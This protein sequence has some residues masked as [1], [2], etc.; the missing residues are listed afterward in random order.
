MNEEIKDWGLG[1]ALGKKKKEGKKK[2]KK[3]NQFYI[4]LKLELHVIVRAR[5]T[6]NYKYLH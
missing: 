4:D 6:N 3:E 2:F 5:I 1:A